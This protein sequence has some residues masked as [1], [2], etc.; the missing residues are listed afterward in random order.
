MPS[1]QRQKRR[2]RPSNRP[3]AAPQPRLSKLQEHAKRLLAQETAF[4]N[5]PDFGQPGADDRFPSLMQDWPTQAVDRSRD[6]IDDGDI[7]TFVPRNAS[8]LLTRDQEVA[9]FLR[10]N[11]AKYRVNKLRAKLSVTAPDR[12]VVDLID[13]LLTEANEIRNRIVQANVRLVVSIAKH[14]THSEMSLDDLASE[15]NVVLMRAIETFDAGR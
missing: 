5:H 6:S 8:D 9:L 2:L 4:I 10:I 15:G 1:L 7:A 14:F 12:R 3:A 13:A 11:Y